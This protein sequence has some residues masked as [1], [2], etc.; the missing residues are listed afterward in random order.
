MI[1]SFLGEISRGLLSGCA[2]TDPIE[3]NNS[4]QLANVALA[5]LSVLLHQN[6]ASTLITVILRLA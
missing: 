3:A 1:G 6:R 4:P 5:D 2:P